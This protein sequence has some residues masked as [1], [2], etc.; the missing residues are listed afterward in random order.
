VSGVSV[1][2]VTIT[3]AQRN[4]LQGHLLEVAGIA[5]VGRY[6]LTAKAPPISFEESICLL[7]DLGWDDAVSGVVELTLSHAALRSLF[8]RLG[9][10]LY[11]RAPIAPQRTQLVA[12]ACDRV[13]EMLEARPEKGRLPT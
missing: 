4:A 3:I 6:L 1:S 10:M 7:T 13:L 2:P 12:E 5:A 11:E 9:Q 8:M